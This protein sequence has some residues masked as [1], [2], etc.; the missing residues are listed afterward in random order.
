MYTGSVK[1]VGGQGNV[2]WIINAGDKKKK[3][4]ILT[5]HIHTNIK[6]FILVL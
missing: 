2:E 3:K 4:S 6:S 1:D 5:I